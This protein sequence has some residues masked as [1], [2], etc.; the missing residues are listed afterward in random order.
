MIAATTATRKDGSSTSSGLLAPSST[1]WPPITKTDTPSRTAATDPST[2]TASQAQR[3]ALAARTPDRADES[4]RWQLGHRSV[5][6]CWP[7]S[8]RL[9]SEGW[10]A[11][12]FR[13]WLPKLSAV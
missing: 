12:R 5:L 6:A 9:T 13:S 7:A 10:A 1:T 3:R 11:T 2:P 8:G 4:G